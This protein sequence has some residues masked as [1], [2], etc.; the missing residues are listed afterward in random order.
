[1]VSDV[2]VALL[3]ATDW[4]AGAAWATGQGIAQPSTRSNIAYRSVHR[5]AFGL[6]SVRISAI[7]PLEA[8]ISKAAPLLVLKI[9]DN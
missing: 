6:L 9:Q 5:A 2:V 8:T 4:K 1:M 7:P 3:V